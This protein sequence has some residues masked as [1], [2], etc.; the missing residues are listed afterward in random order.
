[1]VLVVLLV[2]AFFSVIALAV[3]GLARLV[4]SSGAAEPKPALGRNA[5]QPSLAGRL[6]RKFFLKREEPES[7]MGG[8]TERD[9]N[10]EQRTIPMDRGKDGIWRS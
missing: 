8:N 7:A 5:G 10:A 9:R 6:F 2:T 4:L 1:V 3:G